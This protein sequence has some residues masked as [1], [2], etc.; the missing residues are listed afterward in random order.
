MITLKKKCYIG[1]NRREFIDWNLQRS[2]QYRTASHINR[3]KTTFFYFGRN[4][5]SYVT[6]LFNNSTNYSTSYH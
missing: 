5:Y 4:I 3:R 6:Y 2:Q 1:N